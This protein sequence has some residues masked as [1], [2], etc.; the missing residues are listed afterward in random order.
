MAKMC[1]MEGCKTSEGMCNHEKMMAVV[2]IA[3]IIVVA[4]KLLNVF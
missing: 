2:M 1:S 4:A 3:A